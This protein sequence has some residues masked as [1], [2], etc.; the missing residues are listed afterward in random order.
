MKPTLILC[1]TAMLAAVAPF[2]VM[3]FE[4]G[5]DWIA[6][7][8]K[9]NNPQ[10]GGSQTELIS[11]LSDEEMIVIDRTIMKQEAVSDLLEGRD[12]LGQ[13]LER[14]RSLSTIAGSPGYPANEFKDPSIRQ[15]VNYATIIL[16][17]ESTFET[18]LSLE[19]LQCECVYID[20]LKD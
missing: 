11:R 12:T 9:K 1:H 20:H 4:A 17:S 13:T 7:Y 6:A 8:A 19:D 10:S 15:I 18:R 16:R 5:H 14:F 3:L 2:F